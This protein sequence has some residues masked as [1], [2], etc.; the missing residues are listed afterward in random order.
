M[1]EFIDVEITIKKRIHT[2]ELDSGSQTKYALEYALRVLED[3]G[4]SKPVS[5]DEVIIKT[6]PVVQ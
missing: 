2:T 5:N 4:I 6:K 1:S 3:A